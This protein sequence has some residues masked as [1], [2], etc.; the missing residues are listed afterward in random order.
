M[1]VALRKLKRILEEQFSPP[2]KVDLRDE[3]G[4]IGVNTSRRFR[5]LDGMQRQ[6]IIHDL[7]A[8]SLTPAERRQVVLL[9]GVTPEEE[10]ANARDEDV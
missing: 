7:L 3:D 10:L 1:A 2:D 4:I 9:V 5:R 8:T 6:D